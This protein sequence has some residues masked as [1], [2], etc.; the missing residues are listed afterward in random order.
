MW[1]VH[2]S[3]WVNHHVFGGKPD[4]MISSRVYVEHHVRWE[5]VIDT[6]FYYSRGQ[7]QHCRATYL[8][9]SR[10]E[11]KK[12]HQPPQGKTQPPEACKNGMAAVPER[13]GP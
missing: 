6:C 8:W 13:S 12:R 9:E 11:A 3:R 4:Q 2:L 5:R 7:R 1:K 10:Y